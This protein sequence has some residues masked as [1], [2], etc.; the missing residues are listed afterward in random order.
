MSTITT[1]NSVIF[2]SVAGLYDTPL[3]LQGYSADAA[4][5]SDPINTVEMSMGIDGKLSAGYTPVASPFSITLQADSASNEIFETWQATQESAREALP[6]SM[7]VVLPATGRKY[8]GTRGF[9]TSVPKVPTGQK[10]LQPRTYT[11]NFE[12]LQPAAA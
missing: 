3:Q 6:S 10:T 8:T 5:A 12:S 9:L 11:I 7:T 1:A 2:L 4:F